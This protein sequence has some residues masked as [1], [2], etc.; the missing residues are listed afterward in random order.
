MNVKSETKRSTSVAARWCLAMIFLLPAGAMPSGCSTAGDPP[1]GADMTNDNL[2]DPVSAGNAN[3]GAPDGNE[4]NVNENN[5]DDNANGGDVNSNQNTSAGENANAAEPPPDPTWKIV[6]SDLPSALLSVRI[7]SNGD[8]YAVGTDSLDG[9]G[10]Y[11]LRYD[12]F[13]WTRLTTGVDGDLWWV[14]E[15]APG[16]IWMCGAA[17]LLLRY[18]PS[19]GAFEQFDIGENDLETLYGIWGVSAGDIWTVGGSVT[20][21]VLFHFNGDAW[22]Q[23]DV[24]TIGDGSILPTLFK[25]WGPAAD[26]FFIVG[27]GGRTLHYDGAEFTLELTDTRRS[28]FTVHGD[29]GGDRVIAVGAAQ[30]GEIWERAED[31]TW[32][33]VSPP[34]SAGIN[35]INIGPSGHAFAV[36]VE[37]ST[38]R[39]ES[40]G[41]VEQDNGLTDVSDLAFHAVW[42][43]AEGNA[44]AVGGD[45]VSKPLS[46]GLMAYYGTGDPSGPIATTD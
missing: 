30:P 12:G 45:L 37:A 4:A 35:G 23:I 34:G 24:T 17:R 16:D 11:V 33:E 2:G 28:L 6:H 39:F 31:G 27:G 36:G 41:W 38:F 3:D 13:E 19:T 29:L 44:W 5:S 25:V 9:D 20:R 15:A 42:V 1:T 40:Q 14:H 32:T 26:D 46:Q 43:D 7:V 8:L 10:P 22:S 21:G 18:R